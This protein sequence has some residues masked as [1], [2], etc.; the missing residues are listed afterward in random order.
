[1]VSKPNF[2]SGDSDESGESGDS[3]VSVKLDIAEMLKLHS[4]LYARHWKHKHRG[5]EH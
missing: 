4:V 3:G 2:D 5:P 1:M